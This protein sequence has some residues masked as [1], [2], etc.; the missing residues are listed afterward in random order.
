[1]G[2]TILESTPDPERWPWTPR[3]AALVPAWNEALCL[4]EHVQSFQHLCYPNKEMILCA[5]GADGTFELARRMAGPGLKVLPQ[6]PG[7]GKQSALRKCLAVCDAEIVLLT[8]ADCLVSDDSFLRLIAP[9]VSG[10]VD[11]AT[12]LCEPKVG[13]RDN[14][15]VQYQWFRGALWAHRMPCRVRGLVGGNSAVRRTA[16]MAV[17]GFDAAV[18]IGTDTHLARRLAKSGHEI[19]S[20][21]ESRALTE[22]P[23]S[24][25]AY[26]RKRRRVHRTQLI[27]GVSFH[28]WRDVGLVLVPF[29]LYVLMLALPFFASVLGPLAWALPLLILG[30]TLAKQLR[31]LVLGS[32]LAGSRLTWANLVS[33]P[34]HTLLEV[35]AMLLAFTD[36]LSPRLRAQW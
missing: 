8:D 35:V 36:L 20:V 22:F 10:Q 16:L 1:M 30:A 5:G 6:A 18:R 12:G 29:G 17:G 4:E 13:Q 34:Y 14:L 32:R 26:V 7:E 21:P 27:Q 2:D 33:L 9:I 19:R 3:V 28:A 31:R 11:A 15:L 24:P 23:D 25:R